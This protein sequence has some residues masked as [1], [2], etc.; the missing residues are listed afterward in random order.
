[1]DKVIGVLALLAVIAFLGVLVGFV[2]DV[3][4][5]IV[6]AVVV[7]LAAWDFWRMLRRR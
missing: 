7:A 2:P 6:C 3:D 4:L 1:M 5:I